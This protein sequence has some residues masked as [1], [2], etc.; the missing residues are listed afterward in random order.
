MSQKVEATWCTLLM[1]EAMYS[2]KTRDFEVSQDRLAELAEPVGVLVA[3]EE[4][5]HEAEGLELGRDHCK[6]LQ[7]NQCL[8]QPLAV[9]E[10][11]RGV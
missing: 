8:L 5:I 4:T 9:E 7:L 11:S 3:A 2:Q 1:A 6:Q 10:S